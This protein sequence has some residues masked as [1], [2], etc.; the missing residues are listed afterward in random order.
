[1]L[2]DLANAAKR[3]GLEMHMG[4]TKVL[5]NVE[6]EDREGTSYINIGGSQEEI[7]L[8]MGS[9]MYLGRLLCLEALHDEEVR[10]RIRR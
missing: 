8:L 3:V 10:H 5:S 2:K 4:K 9:S 6:D 1:M 7:L